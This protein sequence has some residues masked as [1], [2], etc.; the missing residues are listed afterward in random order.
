M[1]NHRYL[2]IDRAKHRFW[3]LAILLLVGASN[4][5]G[6][7]SYTYTGVVTDNTKETLPGV[8][9]VVKGT[10]E[11]TISSINGS[12]NLTT[13]KPTET[14][15]FS[16]VGKLKQEIQA[17]AGVPLTIVMED[18]TTGLEGIVVIGY[19][20]QKKSVVTGAITSVKASDIENQQIVRIE[21]ALQG[22]TSGIT[23]TSS[24]G[25]PGAG[26]TVRIRG[27]TSIN[28]CDPLYVVDGMPVD[29]GGIDYL[30]SSDI[31]SIEVLK[32]AASAA[33]YG[34]RAAAGVILISTKKGRQ[35]TIQT[36]GLAVNYNAY[37]GTQ[38]PA[39][40]LDLLNATEYATLRNEAAKNAGQPEPFADPALLGEGTDWQ[41]L[42]FNKNAGIM[43][44]ELSISGGN[45]IS[46][47]YTSIGYF[48][49]QG[50]VASSISNYNRL[51]L[52]LN[53][54]HK[55]K[56]WLTLGNNL[57]YSHIKS[58]GG[59]NTNSEYGG[60]L[61][62]AV[63]LDPVTPSVITDP[64][65]ANNSPYNNHPVERDA[66]G[67]PYGISKYVG[68]ELTNPLA[69]IQTKQGNF[70]WSD[71]LVGNMFVE[72]EVI[73]GLKLK[74]DMGAKLA[75]WGGES[76]NPVT[77]LNASS[78][79]AINS[80]SKDNAKGF[81]WNF[82]NTATYTK[83][84]DKHNFSALIG[85]SASIDNSRGTGVTYQDLPITTFE[86]ASMN[87]QTTA[88]KILAYGWESPDHKIA[89]QFSRVTYNFDEKYLFT[90]IVRRDGSS[91]FGG[92]NKFGIFPSA[93]A[94]WVISRE[95]FWNRNGAISFLKLRGSYGV[96]GYDEI[97]DFKYLSTI[98]GGRNY[99]FGNDMYVIGYSPN[100]PS[101]PDLK[102]EE[103]S[104]LNFG[105]EST[106]FDYFTVVFDIYNKKTSGMLRPII[107]PLYVGVSGNPMGNVASMSNKGVELEVGFHKKFNEVDFKI[108]GNVSYV[109][110][111][112][113]DLGTVKFTTGA[114]FQSSDYELSRNIVG[115]AIGSFYGFEVLG[116]FQSNAEVNY[117]KDEE[118]NKIQPNAKPGDFKFADL[119]G[120]GK[121]TADDRKVI[122][123]PTPNW[124]YGFTT[125]A[126]YKG[127]DL[128][129]FGQ[130]VAGN[131]VFNALRRL[132]VVG[133]N[134][135]ADALGRW[136]AEGSSDFYPRLILGDPNKN[137][138][139][140]SSFYLTSGAYFRVKSFQIGYTLPKK[141]VNKIGLQQ[142]RLYV[143][144][145]NLL[146][147]T[148]YTG[149]DP[150]IGGGSYG[151]DRGVY[152]QAKSFMAGI[153]VSF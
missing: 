68:Q 34:T 122:G 5:F 147:F 89:S 13:T 120:D 149:F 55:V 61:A 85:I 93:S 18:A 119:N 67:N 91:R 23:V 24:S 134:W 142:L 72:I 131:Q 77:Y 86:E 153:N 33:I 20:T 94:G 95:E 56:K 39:K 64:I 110:N 49:Q 133:A 96:V 130:G 21:N 75:F 16:F 103:T 9:I 144:A 12:F 125:T 22:R 114:G 32:D 17:V 113:T 73:K 117:Y 35:G 90:G 40:K 71:N 65:E 109:K 10:T 152:P 140:P 92:N 42:I 28:N 124:T 137:F 79:T 136:T 57:G 81:R 58:Q 111:E 78:S 87:Y 128:L 4:L 14:L 97:G 139:S 26:S 43:N 135:T 36:N 70:G 116:I 127:F 143:S 123:D 80:Y 45:E 69:Y 51:N 151:I 48:D 38:S 41:E 138:S 59:L 126:N 30:N 76:F 115:E 60:P 107:L 2:K 19:G 66:D 146:T 141:L 102:W 54:T 83:T 52:R 121:I 129:I 15:V 50:V 29:N 118:G 8:S 88:D 132:D 31:E 148:S 84:I 44:H 7:K 145:N 3:L 105:F 27:T 62:S 108:N 106:V 46:N 11:G 74:S 100:A 99:T 150:E 47:F 104:Q 101:N 63:N 6:Q 98:G 1:I 25:S 82:E 112:I 37:F 53:S